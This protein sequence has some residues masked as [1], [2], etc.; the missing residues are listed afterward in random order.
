MKS[1]NDGLRELAA[2]EAM[3][4]FVNNDAVRKAQLL[5]LYEKLDERGKL[6]ILAMLATMVK[7]I[8]SVCDHNSS[9][10]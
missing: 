10:G 7:M 6:T 8:E 1:Q 5:A 3:S 4:S 2:R 9:A